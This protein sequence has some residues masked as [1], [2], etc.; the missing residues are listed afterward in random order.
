VPWRENPLEAGIGDI[1]KIV[2]SVKCGGV[3]QNFRRNWNIGDMWGRA[4]RGV[5]KNC[6]RQRR[7]VAGLNFIMIGL[8]GGLDDE[9]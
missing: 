9:K 7:F 3:P 5:V 8:V 1:G 4:D 6:S 2:V